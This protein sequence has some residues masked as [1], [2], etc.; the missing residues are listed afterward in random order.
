MSSSY[1]VYFHDYCLEYC[2]ILAFSTFFFLALQIHN[3]Y[4]E[5]ITTEEFNYKSMSINNNTQNSKGKWCA[6]YTS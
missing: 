1:K 4:L 5:R 3:L 2:N 6:T